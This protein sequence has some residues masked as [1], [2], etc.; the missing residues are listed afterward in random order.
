MRAIVMR[1]F[2]GP[3]VLRLEDV[4]EP[5]PR[6]GHACVEVALAGVNYADVHVRGDTYLAPVELPY[7]P[8]NE[9]VGTVDGGRRVVGLTR[10]GGYAERALLHRRVTW[11]VPDAVSDEQAVALALQ[12][13]SAWHLLF[14]ALRLTEGESVVVPAA[15]GGVG[16]LAVQLA[17]RAGAKVVALAGSP[18]KRQLALD[19]GAHAVVDSTAED[20]TERILEAAGGPVETALEMTGGATFARTLAAVAPRGRLAVYGFAGGELASVSTRELMERSI[21]VSGFWLPQLYADRTA[22]PTSMRA[23]FD[24]VADGSLRTLTG[25]TYAL[26]EAAQ[27]H[28]DLAARTPTGKL[29]LDVT[30]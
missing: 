22:L 14:T 18:A 21:T 13:N 28:H 24:A 10:G 29:A 11:D 20:L 3:D 16:T 7:T 27:A 26:G 8:G 9:V 1:E 6:A 19:L 4:P 12:G 25:A 17:A 30:R 2:G 15:A 5:E 23:L